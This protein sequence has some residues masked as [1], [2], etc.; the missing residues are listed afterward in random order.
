MIS[1][2]AHYTYTFKKY[3]TFIGLLF[4]DFLRNETEAAYAN[5]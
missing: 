4:M 2:W 1:K 3:C 5:S